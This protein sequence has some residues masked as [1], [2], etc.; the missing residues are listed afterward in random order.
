MRIRDPMHFSAR[1]GSCYSDIDLPAARNLWGTSFEAYIE[2]WSREAKA[3]EEKVAAMLAIKC[4][5]L[6]TV[7]FSS[8]GAGERTDRSEWDI[9]ELDWIL[10]QREPSERVLDAEY[11]VGT[12]VRVLIK[13][14]TARTRDER[15][16]SFMWSGTEWDIC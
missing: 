3:A 2:E 4:S 8:F 11:P 13:H 5:S 10:P 12:Q 7:S 6:K 14:T 9:C 15:Q 16:I 1:W